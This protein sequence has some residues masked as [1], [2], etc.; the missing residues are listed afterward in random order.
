MIVAHYP[1]TP[2]LRIRNFIAIRIGF[3]MLLPKHART[4]G[5]CEDVCC[6]SGG[7]SWSG[8]SGVV[9]CR[10]LCVRLWVG[11]AALRCVAI[12]TLDLTLFDFGKSVYLCYTILTYA[13]NF[14][15]IIRNNK[16]YYVRHFMSGHIK[17]NKKYIHIYIYNLC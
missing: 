7:S 4:F 9:H 17:K 2:Y 5:I 16:T 1:I 6:W 15:I 8:D 12:Y 13:I 10:W 11:F 3:V 14:T